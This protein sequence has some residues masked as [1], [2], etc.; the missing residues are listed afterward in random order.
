MKKRKI[1]LIV[2]AVIVIAK[3]V[4]KIM[5]ALSPE[6]PHVYDTGECYDH[7]TEDK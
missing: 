3:I 7:T 2:G 4:G 5:E 6:F 1:L